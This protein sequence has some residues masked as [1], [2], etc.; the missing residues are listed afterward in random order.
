MHEIKQIVL[1]TG[2]K[3]EAINPLD[4]ASLLPTKT[5]NIEEYRAS[6]RILCTNNPDTIQLVY[7]TLS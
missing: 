5:D 4:L 7:N 6:V 3:R 1:I 2:K